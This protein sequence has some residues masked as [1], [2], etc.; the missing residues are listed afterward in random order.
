MAVL[1]GW[2]PSPCAPRPRPAPLRPHLPP[3]GAEFEIVEAPLEEPMASQYSR[4][5]AAWSKL[6]REF[7]AAEEAAAAAEG[8]AAPSGERP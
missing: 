6:F 7:L 2:A 5:A 4:A 3:A 8:S 1:A